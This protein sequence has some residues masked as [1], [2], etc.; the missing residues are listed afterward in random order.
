MIFLK[1][2]ISRR[3][4]KRFQI[5]RRIRSSGLF[6][7]PWYLAQN[8]D[9]ARS[10][11]DPIMHYID[12]GAAEF[13]NPNPDFDTEYYL[14]RYHD[15]TI[16]ATN[17]LDHYVRF[18]RNERR[19][20][21]RAP[22]T[23]VPRSNER[24]PAGLR[25]RV[26]AFY[27]PQFYPTPENDAFWG[28]GCT[29]WTNVTRAVPQF[30]G[31]YQPRLPGD[32]GFYD[33]RVKDIQKEQIEIAMRYGVSGFC[34]HFYWFNGKRILE[35]PI[36]QFVENDAHELGF[37]INWANEPWSR[38]WDGRA[39]EVLIPQS[40]SPEDDLAF[41]ENVSGYFRD[42]RYIRI[43]GKP[44]LMIY[45]PGLFPSAAETAQRWRAYCRE[46]G[47]GEI[48]LAYPQAFDTGDP[49]EFGFDAAVE[50]P[51]NPGA[52]P[53][54]SI[55][56]LKSDFP[57]KIYDW[58]EL[59]NRSRAYP[60]VPY[61]LFRGLCPSWDNTARRM[62]AAYILANA[63]PA[64]YK[65][66]LTNAV[67]DTC[68]RFADFDSRLI[69]INAWNDWAE[70]AYLEPDARYGYAYLQATRDV[71]SAPPAAGMLTK[72]PSWRVLFVS[73]D[74]NVGG[75][76]GSLL[77]IVQWLQAHTGLEIK[78]LCLLGGPRLEQFRRIADTVLLDDL[79][80]QTDTT[81]AK[82][83]RITAWCGGRPDLIYC[84]SLATGRVH[85]QLGDL[86]SPILTHARELATSIAR[87]AKDDMADVVSNT[88]RFVAC[89]GSVRDYLMAAYG[90]D[91]NAIDV[92]PSAVPQSSVDHGLTEIQRLGSRR[93]AGWPTD[94]TIVVGSGVGMSFRKGADLFIEVARILRARG[95]EDYHFYWLG[96]FPGS[97][98]DEILGTWAQQL[99]RLRADGL[100]ERVTILG[101][102]DDVRAH[103]RGADLFLLTSRE[104]PFGRVVLEAAFA[105]LPVVC[106]AG[107]GGAPDFVEEDAGI[108]VDW[109]NAAAMADATLKLI[110]DKPLRI[111]LGKQANTK[112]RRF[113]S[114]D[115]VFPRLLS[116]MREVA[117]KRPAVSIIVPNY[118]CAR[119]LG[120]R[121]D[122][123]LDQSFQDF[124]L[125]ILDDASTDDSQSIL[126]YYARVH[127]TRVIVSES[128]SGTPY[129]QWFKGMTLATADLIWIAEADDVSAPSFLETL[130]P[131]FRDP[132]VK[133][134]FC[135]SKIIDDRSE[136]VGDYVSNRYLTDISNFKWKRSYQV[137]AEQEVNEGLGVKNTVPNIS[138]AVFR[139]FDITPNLAKQVLSLP[140]SGDWYF[141]L[142]AIRNGS[143]AY[144]CA[145]L[146]RHRRHG[147]S[148]SSV[149]AASQSEALLHTRQ[150]IH[151]H[152]LQTY[153]TDLAIKLKMAEYVAQLW[154]ELFPGRP[155]EEMESL[156]SLK[157]LG[158]F[159]MRPESGSTAMSGADSVACGDKMT[160]ADVLQ[161]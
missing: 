27:L 77:D 15:V 74:A 93:L 35:M 128:N 21:R 148:V 133:F 63:T 17:P 64:R 156:Y 86:G 50:F 118:N 4:W 81:A 131:L 144:E 117:N 57:G 31:H 54:I 10:G 22:A 160:T 103:L 42:R 32:L 52:F 92:L 141:I 99:D 78:V 71:L 49:A 16:A 80:S 114:T 23:H 134:A 6:D 62:E 58:T 154:A 122:S 89:S 47:I 67:A 87:F 2:L 109:A 107:S 124:E 130:V 95:I 85:A 72:G 140:T 145:P 149:I 104:E 123:I 88:R 46:A 25:A 135:A 115:R 43:G 7:E 94:K 41:I 65:E 138:A 153:K 48:F 68:D 26:I 39:Q 111:K 91:P 96:S 126:D 61:T 147:K 20:T 90:V 158:E 125:I 24:R 110:R 116:T 51:P 152:V 146:N 119:Y 79:V 40:H 3:R 14:S 105:E 121:M 113:Y 38:R 12:H 29:E 106:F 33:L 136:V 37:C 83:A 36:T 56:T 132:S 137:S 34:F 45:R 8:P 102:V 129:P 30:D 127:G 55:T 161:R 112:A 157:A 108:I 11:R 150:K 98:R 159:P 66:W 100:D 13:R 82:L 1:S 59:L 69:F 97:E 73:H 142:E 53:E 19:E 70:G 28:K 18:G 120:E 151:Q 75:A 5:R 60:Q 84:N 143:V 155:A 44:L 76:Q 9:V 139:K 101:K